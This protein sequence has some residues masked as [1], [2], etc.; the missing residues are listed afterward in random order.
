MTLEPHAGGTEPLWGRLQLVCASANPDKVVEIATLLGDAVD[1]VPRPLHVPDV[2][3]DADTLLENAR[4]KAVALV[5][6]TGLPA[7]ADDTG[8][9]VDALGGAPGVFTGRFAGEGATYAD[10]RAKLLLELDG[11]PEAERGARFVTVAIVVWPGGRELAVEG[12]CSGRISETERGDR[13]FGYDPVFVPDEGD[14][15]TF[16]EMSEDEKHELSHR[17]RALRAL[18]A[19][20]DELH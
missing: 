8:L 4:L 7:L 13:G 10:N 18:V 15:R 17:G 12:S 3:E 11:V 5:D 16:A 1:L 20:L 6:A 9:E 19:E 2:A 14:G